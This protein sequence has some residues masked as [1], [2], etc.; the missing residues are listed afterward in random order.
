MAASIAYTV[1]WVPPSGWPAGTYNVKALV[2]ADSTKKFSGTSSAFALSSGEG[3]TIPA[4]GGGAPPTT[5]D[6]LAEVV[7]EDGVF[8]EEVTIES[9]DSNVEIVIPSGTTGLT[10]EG[11]PLSE[12]TVV[13]ADPPAP[14]AN[15]ETIAVDYDLGPDGAT[16]APPISLTFQYNPDQIPEGGSHENLSIAYYDT[17]SGQWVELDASD[18]EIDPVTNTITARISH[19]T[20]FSIIAHTAP[21]V[22]TASNLT[23]SPSAVDAGEKVNISATIT[24]TGDLAGEFK[25]ALKINGGFAATATVVLNGGAT[26]KVTF[27]SIQGAPGTYTVDVSGQTGQFTVTG[28]TREAVITIPSWSVELPTAPAPAPTVPTVIP[29]PPAP[30]PVPSVSWWLL[31]AIA[32]ATIIVVGLVLWLVAFRRE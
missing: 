11:E 4:V 31:G 15:T 5:E 21:A 13:R 9:L 14:P 7:T 23:I 1:N 26:G 28:V 32:L 22:F 3:G 20:Y 6:I 8:T 27:T 24:N 2:Y 12:I 18:I 16:F 19:F 25:A 30:A 17:D 10:E 29:A